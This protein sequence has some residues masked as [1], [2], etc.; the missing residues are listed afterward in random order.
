MN[1]NA[2]EIN[3]IPLKLMMTWRVL[4]LVYMKVL[5]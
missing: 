5:I 1:W 3:D 4:G 2:S